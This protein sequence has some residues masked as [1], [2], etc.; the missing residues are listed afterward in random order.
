[1]ILDY[2]SV[3]RGFTEALWDELGEENMSYPELMA[4][5]RQMRKLLKAI[6]ACLNFFFNTI[7]F[8]SHIGMTWGDMC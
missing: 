7:P 6:E 2:S 4:F 1:M 5:W 8:K 3:V